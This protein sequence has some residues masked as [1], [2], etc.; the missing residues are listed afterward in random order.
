MAVGDSHGVSGHWTQDMRAE[1]HKL[2][3][4]SHDQ[5]FPY[6]GGRFCVLHYA[7]ETGRVVGFVSCTF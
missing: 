3:A 4:R 5:A 2:L 6:L 1:L 7:F